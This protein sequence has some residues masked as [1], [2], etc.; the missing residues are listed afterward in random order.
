MKPFLIVLSRSHPI[1]HGLKSYATPSWHLL[2]STATSVSLD[3]S[4]KEGT[5]VIFVTT[6]CS[7]LGMLGKGHPNF[8]NEDLVQ[9]LPNLNTGLKE[10]QHLHSTENWLINR[11]GEPS[12]CK[13]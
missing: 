12:L 5:A 13:L 7:V 8:L 2:H 6:E 3:S 9:W 4:L 1:S 11:L 10:N